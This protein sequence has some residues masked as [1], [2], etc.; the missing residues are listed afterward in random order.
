MV[1]MVLLMF[2]LSSVDPTTAAAPDTA[3]L[4]LPP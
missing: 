2:L 4:I 3:M 1:G